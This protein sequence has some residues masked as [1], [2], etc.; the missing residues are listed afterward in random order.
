[1]TGPVAAVQQPWWARPA[2]VLPALGIGNRVIV[3][4]AVVVLLLAGAVERLVAHDRAHRIAHRL[5]R[6]SGERVLGEGGCA[7]DGQDRSGA[8]PSERER[9]STSNPS[10]RIRAS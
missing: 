9:C 4:L 3:V 10:A 5:R 2:I 8:P 6:H 1:M 7:R